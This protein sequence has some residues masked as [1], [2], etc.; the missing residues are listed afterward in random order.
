MIDFFDRAIAGHRRPNRAC[1]SVALT[2][3]VPI[4]GSDEIYSIEFEGR[5]PLPPGKGVSALYYL[6]SPAATSTTMGI[7]LL[8]G[9]C[10]HRRRPRGRAARGDR[11]RHVREAALPQRGSDR[12]AHPHGPQLTSSAKSSASSATSST[13]A[14]R[15]RKPRRCTS[16]SVRCRRPAMTMVIKTSGEPTSADTGGARRA[17]SASI[18]QQ[19]V[20]TTASLEQ[21]VADAGALP[22]VQAT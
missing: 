8:E 4:S 19:P 12:Q 10:V 5:P 17:S 16:R 14:L 6:V 20:A 15:T 1:E 13:T 7:P 2:S 21:L 18:P 9:T 11:Q 22:R 3:T